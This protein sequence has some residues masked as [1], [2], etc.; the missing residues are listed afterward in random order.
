MDTGKDMLEDEINKFDNV[1][2]RTLFAKYDPL[3]FIDPAACQPNYYE[4][5]KISG[6]MVSRLLMQKLEES[7]LP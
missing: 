6:E 3:D 1:S 4:V 2:F 5:G 7:R